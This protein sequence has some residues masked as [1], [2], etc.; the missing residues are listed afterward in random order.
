MDGERDVR[1]GGQGVTLI[2]RISSLSLTFFLASISPQHSKLRNSEQSGRLRR[3]ML[4]E[5]K[6]KSGTIKRICKQSVRRAEGKRERNSTGSE[7]ERICRILE[8]KRFRNRTLSTLRE[9]VPLFHTDSRVSALQSADNAGIIQKMNSRI[10]HL[11]HETNGC[12]LT[13]WMPFCLSS[14]RISLFS[15]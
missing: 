14:A 15:Q 2:Q 1:G 3:L 7:R 10:F 4:D 11:F 8:A 9:P 5:K 12:L 6:K 13:A